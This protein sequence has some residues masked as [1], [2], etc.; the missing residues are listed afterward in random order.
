MSAKARNVLF[1]LCGVAGLALKGRY[2]GPYQAVVHSYCGNIAAS[3][4]VYFILANLR[5]CMKLG[6]LPTAGCALAVVGLF[7]AT[8]GFH[9]MANTYDPVDYA[10]N[11]AG[12][13]FALLAE[14]AA[15]K[16]IRGP[17]QNGQSA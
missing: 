7:E 4:A 11:A 8:N 17:K 12:I 13:G 1:T 9:L 10:A 6:R 3:F 15:S 2:A 16:V 5:F 14:A